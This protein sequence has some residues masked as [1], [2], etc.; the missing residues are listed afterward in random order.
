M[1]R[2]KPKKQLKKKPT[3]T[4]ARRKALVKAPTVTEEVIDAAKQLIAL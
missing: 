4:P 1:A 3:K 2:R